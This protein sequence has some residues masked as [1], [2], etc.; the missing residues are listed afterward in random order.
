[1]EHIIYINDN[2]FIKVRISSTNAHIVDSYKITKVE[3]MKLYIKFIRDIAFEAYGFIY[4]RT[5]KQWLN[6]WKAHNLLYSKGYKQSQTKDVDLNEG[7]TIIRQFL[8]WILS[9]FYK[10]K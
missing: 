6:E 3:D 10:N 2:D 5:E 4:S 8:Y 7:E 1:M 9:I